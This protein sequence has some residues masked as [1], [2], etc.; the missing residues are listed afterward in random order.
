[1]TT[2]LVSLVMAVLRTQTVPVAVKLAVVLAKTVRKPEVDGQLLYSPAQISMW[3][4][5]SYG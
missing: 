4:R 3:D 5:S 2:P 1:M